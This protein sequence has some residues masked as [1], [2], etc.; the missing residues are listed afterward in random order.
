MAILNSIILTLFQ[1]IILFVI[2]KILNNINYNFRDYISILGIIIPSTIVFY[3]FNTKAMIV[4]LIG[5]AIFIYFKNK[6]IGL[7]SILI[8]F[9]IL[10]IANFLSIWLA[11]MIYDYI[12]TSLIFNILYLII[13]SIITLFFSFIARFFMNQLLRSDLSLNKIY[14]SIVGTLLLIA[15]LLLYS[16]VPNK[17]MSFSDI[18]FIVVMYAVFIIT[19]AILIIT[20]SFSIIRQ[21]QYKRNMQEIENYYKYTLQIENINNEMRKFRHDYVNILSTMS[22]FIRESDMDGLKKYF[23]EEILPMQDSMQMNTIKINGIENL[24]VREIKGLLTTKILQAQEKNIRISIEV[25]EP[26]ERIDMPIINLSRVI[27]I[28]LDNAIEASEKIEDDPLIRI[29]FIKNNDD[30]VMFIVMNKCEPNMPRI[31]TLFQE[32]FSTKGKNRGLGLSTLKELTDATSNVLLDT[33]IDNDYFI[34][35][36]EILNSDS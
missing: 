24:K 4:L 9:F 34:Q 33:T 13:F 35:K 32:N 10:Y 6:V 5:S 3:F 27:G 22:E 26:I 16:Y 15:L 19:I 21:I 25:P 17:I 18:K 30:S 8:I 29:A 1:A 12:E 20:I 28:V 11:A 36:V 31:H 2:I 23:N 14:L 7:V